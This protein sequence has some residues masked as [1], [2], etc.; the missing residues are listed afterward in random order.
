MEIPT[1]KEYE[2]ECGYPVTEGE[3]RRYLKLNF[4]DKLI[5]E[6]EEN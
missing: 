5:D 4:K 3:Y 1:W 2:E 6:S